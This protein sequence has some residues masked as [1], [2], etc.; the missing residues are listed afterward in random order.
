VLGDA[1]EA[2]A[3]DWVR[4]ARTPG[5]DSYWTFHRDA[6]LALL[7]GPGRLTLDVGCGEGRLTRDLAAVGHRVVG[8]D[9]SPTL[10]R[11][12]AAAGGTLGTVLADGAHLPFADGASDL[13]VA[14]MSLQ[15]MDDMEGSVGELARVL[16][17]GGRACLAVT[18]PVNTGHTIDRTDRTRWIIEAGA[19]WTERRTTDAVE[20]DGL[21]MT[22]HSL[23]RP[24]QAYF[25]AVE[26]AGLLVEAV[27]EPRGTGESSRDFPWFLH[28]RARKPA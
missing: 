6:F 7:P 12:A 21:R 15:D 9:R 26:A 22:F 18:H 25:Q 1:W 20:R 4:W 24:L 23:H 28:I 19:Y 13:V 10:A 2:E 11:S 8:L 3:E 16:E 17:P 5:H 14:F 27:C